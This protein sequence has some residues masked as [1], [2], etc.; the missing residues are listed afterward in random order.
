MVSTVKNKICFVN[1]SFGLYDYE[2]KISGVGT[3]R[4]TVQHKKLFFF[5]MAEEY[6]TP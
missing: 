3:E 5:A 4:E 1:T 2:A 6:H